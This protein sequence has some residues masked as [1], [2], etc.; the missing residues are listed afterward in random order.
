M[1]CLQLWISNGW[2]WLQGHPHVR[3]RAHACS[4]AWEIAQCLHVRQSDMDHA[5]T[6]SRRTCNLSLSPS[7]SPS[8]SPTPSPGLSPGPTPSPGERDPHC[9]WRVTPTSCIVR[10]SSAI[11]HLIIWGGRLL[12]AYSTSSF[13]PSF[14]TYSCN[15]LIFIGELSSKR[16]HSLSRSARSVVPSSKHIYSLTVFISWQATVAQLV[17]YTASLSVSPNK[18]TYFTSACSHLFFPEELCCSEVLIAS[19]T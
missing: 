5:G 11:A 4:H 18:M 1:S 2:H 9:W 14:S 17:V 13:S 19:K 12:I 8:L 10:T 7:P 6:S 3:L 16:C 15:S